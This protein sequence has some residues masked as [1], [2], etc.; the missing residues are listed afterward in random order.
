M[1]VSRQNVYRERQIHSV[2]NRRPNISKPDDKP[3]SA[4]F[5]PYA[6]P[7]LNQISKALA[8]HNIKSMGLPHKKIY[9]QLRI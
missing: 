8:R 3:C 4:A 7:I 5:L 9:R 1:D 2:L 6:E